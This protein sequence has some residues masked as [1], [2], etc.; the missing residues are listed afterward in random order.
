MF[1]RHLLKTHEIKVEDL[2]KESYIAEGSSIL[3]PK[4]TDF[5]K[6]AKVLKSSFEY[7]FYSRFPKRY[8]IYVNK[9]Q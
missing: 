4:Y 7:F 3:F 5:F 2:V 6:E 8:S 1:R 9:R